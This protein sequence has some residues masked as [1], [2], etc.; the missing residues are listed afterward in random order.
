MQTIANKH[1]PWWL[2]RQLER[3][4]TNHRR[5]LGKFKEA[6]GVLVQHSCLPA[7]S[8]TKKDDPFVKPYRISTIHGSHIAIRRSLNRGEALL[9]T[10]KLLRHSHNP[11]TLESDELELLDEEVAALDLERAV[12]PAEHEDTSMKELMKEQM[13]KE[14]YRNLQAVLDSWYCQL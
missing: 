2:V 7:W 8:R 1:V 9:C 11:E 3:A 14:G 6:N 12:E 4:K 10:P 13:K 5:L